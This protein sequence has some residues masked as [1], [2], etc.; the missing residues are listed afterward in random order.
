MTRG[1]SFRVAL[2][3]AF[4]VFAGYHLRTVQDPPIE[5]WRLLLVAA[6]ALLPSLALVRAGRWPA[7]AALTFTVVAGGS[8][9]AA[10]WPAGNPLTEPGAAFSTLHRGLRGWLDVTLPYHPGTE[11]QVRVL[12]LAVWL[13]LTLLLAFLL[14]ARPRPLA[15][16]IVAFVP[17]AIV[18]VVYD[19]S[20]PA[21]RAAVFL[22]LAL[23]A[24][25][26]ET[27]DGRPRAHARQATG[28]GAA[29]VIVALLA[30]ALPGV[31][32]GNLL[33]WRDWR[34]VSG[35]TRV[36]VSYV[37]NQSYTGLSWPPTHTEVLKI[38]ADQPS[39]WR[40][41]VLDKFD[42][43]R[44]VQD[45][46]STAWG[47]PGKTLHVPAAE[48]PPGRL[49]KVTT[50]VEVRGLV[51]PYLVAP[52][53]P[54]S[55][56]V[57]S[58]SGGGFMSTN[59]VVRTDH[60]PARG[61]Q[62]TV[63]SAIVDPEPPALRR[64]STNYPESV[65]NT[66]LQFLD[67]GES[68]QPFGAPGREPQTVARLRQSETV[69]Q[70][71]GWLAAYQ[72]AR[73][74]VRQAGARNPY[75]AVAALEAYFRTNYRYDEHVS[76]AGLPGSPLADWV[77]DGQGGYCQ[78]FSGAMAELLRLM[79]IPARVAE[80]F[81]AGTLD[82]SGVYHVDD[83]DAHAWVEAYFPGYGWLPFD[84]TPT[85]DLFTHASTSNKLSDAA[86]GARTAGPN[87]FGNLHRINDFQVPGQ[88]TPL[89]SAGHS[90][91]TRLLLAL[92]ALAAALLA[93][94]VAFK[95][96][97]HVLRSRARD[98]RRL[99]AASRADIV[100]FARDQRL[101]L[102]GTLTNRELA[103][104]LGRAFAVDADGWAVAADRARFGPPAGSPAAAREVRRETR[105]LL[106]ELRHRLQRRERLAGAV[107]VRSLFPG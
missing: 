45:L 99:A 104:E 54:L 33:S 47:A 68:V 73:Q 66:D 15:A 90:A 75:D 39:Y 53:E 11:P 100:A 83:H 74:V 106:S 55:Y 81:T 61:T 60:P 31:A 88:S 51:E 8:L 49:H 26:L 32:R 59:G 52:G 27:A 17:F 87:P 37:W 48:V 98:P 43:T 20:H 102:S 19:L 67:G 29:V 5:G 16:S 64:T 42:G 30:A 13:V 40:A 1:L 91:A 65:V 63:T 46:Q 36:G 25:G 69:P 85:R 6:V 12:V 10:R 82:T 56:A 34:F 24:L 21:V 78:M 22:G 103:G 97:R 50:T 84:P 62:Y 2:Y 72:Q 41:T 105:R 9:A 7:L 3:A 107:S 14:V 86:R 18:A 71:H 57:P 93:A 77:V 92:L 44:W 96:G 35:S 79:G 70:L 58:S 101:A 38:H 4:C 89:P 95:T 76:L 80:G 28:L 23:T 94:I